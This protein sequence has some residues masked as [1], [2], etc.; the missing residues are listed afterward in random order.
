[1]DTPEDQR[2]GFG[3]Q[4]SSLAR[5][6]SIAMSEFCIAPS[7]SSSLARNAGIWRFS[8]AVAVRAVWVS[9]SKR[10]KIFG[11]GGVVPQLLGTAGGTAR[12]EQGAWVHVEGCVIQ[13][14]DFHLE[15]YS[16]A[17]SRG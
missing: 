9:L 5:R 2:V 6:A 16:S 1:M 14:L 4:A 11:E 10:E 3:C 13:L 7:T 17:P 12:S 15:W 8:W